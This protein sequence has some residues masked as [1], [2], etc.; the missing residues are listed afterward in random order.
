MYPEASIFVI[1]LSYGQENVV[2]MLAVADMFCKK[3]FPDYKIEHVIVDNKISTFYEKAGSA[4]TLIS[5]DNSYFEFSGWERGIAYINNKFSPSPK[6]ICIL[7]NDTIHQRNYATGGSHFYEDFVIDNISKKWPSRWA[8]GYVDD[9]PSPTSICGITFSTWIRSN[10]VVFNWN[11]IDLITPL[12]F[13]YPTELLFSDNISDGFWGE[14]APMSQNW[15]AYI[16]CWLFGIEDAQ[17]PEYRLKWL[18]SRSLAEGNVKYFRRKAICILSEHYLTARLLQANVHIFDF[19][20]Y[21]KLPTR[22]LTPYYK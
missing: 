17:F 14:N 16:S 21:P 15:K 1:G 22:H 8:A 2:P 20:T 7:V 5:G 6:D 4:G 10:F 11:C 18:K 13:P 19:N 12:L 3:N 9:F